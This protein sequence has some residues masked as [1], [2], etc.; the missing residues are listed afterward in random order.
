MPI[1]A[2]RV[3]V[4]RALAVAV[5]ALAPV[6]P[7]FAGNPTLATPAP[8]GEP[9]DVE[10]AVQ[11]LPAH[12]G[13][14]NLVGDFNDW[15][16]TATPMGDADGDGRWTATIPLTPGP[17]RYAF[18]VDG[19]VRHEDP[20]ADESG[21]DGRG[22]TC[23]VLYVGGVGRHT[24]TGQPRRVEFSFPAGREAKEVSLV[25]TFNDWVAGAFRMADPDGDGTWTVTRVLAEGECRYGFV[26]DGVRVA[27]GQAGSTGEDPERGTSLVVDDRFAPIDVS[28]GDGEIFAEG[29]RHEQ[30]VRDVNRLSDD[31]LVIVAR[32]WPDDVA[33]AELQI[34]DAAGQVG[35]TI[36]AQRG[37][38]A[39]LSQSWRMALVRPGG[40]P[41]FRYRIV[42]RDGPIS[43]YLAK[44]GP[45]ETSV[46]SA[47]ADATFEYR[48]DSVPRL[49]VPEWA[50]HAVVYEVPPE[51]V[52]GPV[53]S[54][55]A[56]LRDLG[57]DVVR[58][59][60]RQAVRHASA[61]GFR[62][63]A[64]AC[65]AAGMRVIVDGERP[66][67]PDSIRADPDGLLARMDARY[68]ADPVIAFLQRGSIDAAQFDRELAAG[69][70]AYPE[71]AVPAMIHSAGRVDTSDPA[72]QRL[73][74]LF[75]MCYP[76]VPQV[77]GGDEIAT[78][79]AD[80]GGAS[81][82]DGEWER[83][84]ARKETHD[85]YRSLIRLRSAEPALTAGD[86][87]TLVTR[88]RSHA[89][90]RRTPESTIVV[91]LNAGGAPVDVIV[92]LG[93]PGL[94]EASFVDALD[95]TTFTAS[96]GVLTV[97]LD[98]RSGAIL[99]LVPTASGSGP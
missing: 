97:P 95:G 23:S 9:V 45:V 44:G 80:P 28:V 6:A 41:D 42:L 81:P 77:H 18:L 47:A 56:Y 53:P 2:R 30:T 5:A 57:V 3:D 70:A 64:E 78:D 84:P 55:L 40:V 85:W 54:T 36:P 27:D 4:P 88:G 74:A 51:Q 26:A 19:A 13:T 14:V 48:A 82:F 86:F 32:T 96:R 72:R 83:D 43:W 10:F 50:R 67:A 29:L 66:D 38:T 35:C 33:G 65:R 90:A 37:L 62:E 25:G 71:Q 49:R 79:A 76:G 15:S 61:G 94:L 46:A 89:F 11:P 58:L 20:N 16:P 22:G 63:L 7:S 21:D 52:I 59:A 98:G 92:P 75:G 93:S 68:F 8:Q 1:P 91:V 69:R 73:V 60:R 24:F 17:H 12:P 99:R 87:R 34:V 39:P 31:E